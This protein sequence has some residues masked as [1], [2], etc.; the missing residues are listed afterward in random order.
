MPMLEEL[1][2]ELDALLADA[3][4]AYAAAVASNPPNPV[5]AI[6]PIKPFPPGATKEQKIAALH[7]AIEMVQRYLECINGD[8]QNW[9]TCVSQTCADFAT[10]WN[11]AFGIT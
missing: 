11:L 6:C 5:P 2:A 9:A 7:C 10:C 1:Q 3:Q 8:P 4:A